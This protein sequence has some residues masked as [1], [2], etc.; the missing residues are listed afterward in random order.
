MAL[1][2]VCGVVTLGR[3]REGA[4]ARQSVADPSHEL[5]G[6]RV[7]NGTH[8]R[9]IMEKWNADRHRSAVA[10]NDGS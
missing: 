2:R 10:V 1:S 3:S 5:D 4:S 9:R 8:G 7:G 6:F